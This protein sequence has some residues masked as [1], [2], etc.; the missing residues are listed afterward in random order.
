VPNTKF[1]PEEV[2][3]FKSA[4]AA[5]SE[6]WMINPPDYAAPAG[7]EKAYDEM[8]VALLDR[9]RQTPNVSDVFKKPSV[10]GGMSVIPRFMY[11]GA[12]K[13]AVAGFSI[14]QLKRSMYN[15]TSFNTLSAI[16][17][18]NIH[19][20]KRIEIPLG[21]KRLPAVSVDYNLDAFDIDEETGL[22]IPKYNQRVLDARFDAY[23]QGHIESE[24]LSATNPSF[25]EGQVTGI[26][27]HAYRA[28][29]T[30]CMNDPHLYTATLAQSYAA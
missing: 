6:D 5:H 25:C 17:H 18:E 12:A 11:A 28:M 23:S 19:V 7:E 13:A 29:L 14:D 2:T 16:T 4:L 27:F 8:G 1:S 3:S 20:A 10:T 30:I 26:N 15:H 9:V 21:L 22:T 24:A